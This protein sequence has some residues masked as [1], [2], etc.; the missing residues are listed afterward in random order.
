MLSMDLGGALQ[1]CGFGAPEVER[2]FARALA[3]SEE[4]DDPVQTFQALIGLSALHVTRAH[5]DRAREVIERL[6]VPPSAFGY[7]LLLGMFRFHAG[8][9]AAARAVG[10]G[11]SAAA[12]STRP[13]G[14]EDAYPKCLHMT[15]SGWG[16]SKRRD[17]TPGWEP[18]LGCRAAPAQAI[19]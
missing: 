18:T 8:D 9:L 5:F 15:D 19:S 14:Q 17:P 10:S 7:E 1:S 12:A 16:W 3:L 2:N 11:G 13:V 4:T 6:P